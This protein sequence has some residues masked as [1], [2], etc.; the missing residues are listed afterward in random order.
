[1]VSI[2]SLLTQRYTEP[3]LFFVFFF[4]LLEHIYC[5]INP[6]TL[7][8]HFFPPGVLENKDFSV[9]VSMPYMFDGQHF[10]IQHFHYT[11]NPEVYGQF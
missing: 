11:L 5:W 9:K 2:Y 3:N 4:S 6:L 1:M 10:E 7:L 8:F